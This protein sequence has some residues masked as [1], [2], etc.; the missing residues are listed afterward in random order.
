MNDE[1]TDGTRANRVA[2]VTVGW[3]WN[4]MTAWIVRNRLADEGIEAFVV[5]EYVASMYW[6]YANAIGG[7]KVQ[8]PREKLQQ[9]GEVLARGKSEVFADVPRSPV[10]P[11]TRV[12]PR[13]GSGDLHRERFAVR[14]V[15]LCW[16]VFG[17][18]IPVPS[19]TVECFDCGARLGSPKVFRLQ[20]GLR[21]LL[22]LMFIVAFVL[23][24]LNLT[25]HTW[26]EAASDPGATLW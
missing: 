14:V 2:F 19:R 25:G 16:L 18:P 21:H 12:C 22:L 17:L 13:C 1:R 26:Y 5:D 24:L 8:V 10:S 23:G 9:A 4:P 11:G 15:F 20:Y 7:I 6:L 3:F